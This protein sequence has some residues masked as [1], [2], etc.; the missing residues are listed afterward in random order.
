M[1]CQGGAPHNLGTGA[2]PKGAG[3][4]LKVHELEEKS[5]ELGRR[6]NGIAGTVSF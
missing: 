5:S 2:Q 3:L 1:H 4:K 6:E